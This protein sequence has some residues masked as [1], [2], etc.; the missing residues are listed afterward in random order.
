[1]R[2]FS[3]ERFSF[4]LQKYFR[5]AKRGKTEHAKRVGAAAGGTRTP[6]AFTV[7][8]AEQPSILGILAPKYAALLTPTAPIT[9]E[10]ITQI[11]G[12]QGIRPI[13]SS[14]VILAHAA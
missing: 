6:H 10:K 5:H 13:N 2:I 9:A 8:A 3:E 11:H 4:V 7:H 1:L 14:G 12:L